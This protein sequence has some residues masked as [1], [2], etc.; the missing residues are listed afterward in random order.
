M[1][2]DIARG[3]SGSGVWNGLMMKDKGRQKTTKGYVI[4]G[5]ANKVPAK[6]RR[7]DAGLV[8]K[9]EGYPEFWKAMDDLNSTGNVKMFDYEGKTGIA[10][11]ES[12]VFCKEFFLRS[13]ALEANWQLLFLRCIRGRNPNHGSSWVVN[14]FTRAAQSIAQVRL[15]LKQTGIKSVGDFTKKQQAVSDKMQSSLTHDSLLNATP[16]PSGREA[17]GKLEHTTLITPLFEIRVSYS[18]LNCCTAVSNHNC[19]LA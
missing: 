5:D 17:V 15:L 18:I 16:S 8:V 9:L 13:A 12:R 4:K 19:I 2:K 10:W 3:L 14:Q 11:M 7:V 1:M 6:K